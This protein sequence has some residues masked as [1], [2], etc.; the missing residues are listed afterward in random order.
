MRL[1][2]AVTPVQRRSQRLSAQCCRRASLRRTRRAANHYHTQLL[3]GLHRPGTGCMRNWHRLTRVAR[4]SIHSLVG[5]PKPSSLS[6]A[7]VHLPTVPALS[8][9]RSTRT[10]I[11]DAP[12]H[13]TEPSSRSRRSP[14]PATRARCPQLP[15]SA[16]ACVVTAACASI[17]TGTRSSPA[18]NSPRHPWLHP[19]PPT[20]DPAPSSLPRTSRRS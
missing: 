6:V 19:L 14:P 2:G 16:S 8:P 15:V 17:R 18:R 11:S 20:S 5:A 7:R 1:R 10:R 12:N 4:P 9:L 3:R 13:P